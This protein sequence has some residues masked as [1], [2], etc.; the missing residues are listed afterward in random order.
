MCDAMSQRGHCTH[1]RNLLKEFACP[2]IW[3]RALT[4][5]PRLVPLEGWFGFVLPRH[6]HA[7]CDSVHSQPTHG[8]LT[9]PVFRAC[10]DS[11]A[12]GSKINQVN[13]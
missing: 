5:C 9:P 1:Q 10:K 13:D 8:F 7:G 11:Q 6:I 4:L 12:K 3:A 2:G